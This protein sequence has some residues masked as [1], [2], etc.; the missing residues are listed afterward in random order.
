MLMSVTTDS[1][2]EKKVSRIVSKETAGMII[3]QKE[4]QKESDYFSLT[5]EQVN[6]SSVCQ[7]DR[8]H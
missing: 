1:L 8:L 3:I 2:R 4:I 7:L 5:S 6:V